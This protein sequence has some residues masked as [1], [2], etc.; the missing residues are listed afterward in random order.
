MAVFCEAIMNTA[1]QVQR[2]KALKRKERPREHAAGRIRIGNF[3]LAAANRI[4][5]QPLDVSGVEVLEHEIS[6]DN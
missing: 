5:R 4:K 1:R 2:F 6:P 3:T